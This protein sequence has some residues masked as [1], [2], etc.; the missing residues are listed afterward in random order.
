MWTVKYKP[1]NLGEVVDQ[2]E[3]KEKLL[4]WFKNWKPG[5]K[6]ALL[7]GPPGNGKTCTVEALAL[8]KGLDLLETNASD[9]RSENKIERFLGRSVKEAS[10]F[11]VG[12]KIILVDEVD[13]LEA[14]V[15]KGGMR[16]ILRIIKESAFPVVLT[17]NDPW[18]RKLYE[19]RNFCEL[20]EFRKIPIR[21]IVRRLEYIC[22]SE[23]IKADLKILH[24]IAEKNQGDLRGAILDLETIAQGKNQITFEDL[25]VLGKRERE[26][27][28]F[29]AL[30]NI[31][32]THSAISAKLS[33]SN[34]DMDPSEIFWWIEQNVANEYEKPEDLV[35]AYEALARADLFR[36]RI[37]HRQN[38]RMQAY[39]VDLMTAGVSQAKKETYRK[40]TRY[41][42][43]ERLSFY[44]KTMIER[45]KLN[46]ALKRIALKLHCSTRKVKTEFLPYLLYLIKQKKEFKD[47]L[48]STFNL[49]E[50]EINLIKSFCSSS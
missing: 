37:I 28:I 9:V 7:Y 50:E 3:A 29:E 21:D 17:A 47:K 13:G 25:E 48:A 4:R 23:G 35:K 16:A 36:S 8:E 32:K 30:K 24:M 42:R 19:I 2:T 14:S 39:M 5:G 34:V 10:L 46:N 44:S 38:W 27:D 33:V 11:K 18:D 22:K 15:D 1:K 31:F 41:Q 40:F 49:T 45:G 6:A 26:T 12:G 43:P 20:I